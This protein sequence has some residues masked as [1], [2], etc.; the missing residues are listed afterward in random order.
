MIR[1][2]AT[3]EELIA[4]GIGS[5]AAEKMAAGQ[6][7][8]VLNYRIYQG[9]RIFFLKHWDMRSHFGLWIYEDMTE[10]VKCPSNMEG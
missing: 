1:V 8:E 5:E 6:L 4:I 3:V 10:E 9:R 7:F 2:K